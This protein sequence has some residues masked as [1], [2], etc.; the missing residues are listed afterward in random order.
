MSKTEDKCYYSGKQNYSTAWKA[1]FDT[2]S[3]I[4]PNSEKNFCFVFIGIRFN[5][6]EFYKFE[7]LGFIHR[8]CKRWIKQCVTQ[9]N[10]V[11]LHY[12]IEFQYNRISK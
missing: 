2:F 4:F 1:K 10:S 5:F 6:Q 7:M 8:K 11:K 12:Y 9:Y 3:E